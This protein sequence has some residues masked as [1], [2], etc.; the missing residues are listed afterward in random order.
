M[1]IRF[2]LSWILAI[3]IST[4]VSGQF[5]IP[6]ADSLTRGANVV[7]RNFHTTIDYVSPTKMSVHRYIEITVLNE[8]GRKH[9]EFSIAYDPDKPIKKI[10]AHL[11]DAFGK[12]IKTYKGKDIIVCTRNTPCSTTTG[13][14]QLKCF[15]HNILTQS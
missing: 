12:K 11:F 9:G 1:N 10:A 14:R 7:Y 6:I 15:R 2:Y 5:P 8:K 4:A 13:Q 3:S